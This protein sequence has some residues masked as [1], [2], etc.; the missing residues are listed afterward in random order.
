LA[1]FLNR[2]GAFSTFAAR[3]AMERGLRQ[4]LGRGQLRGIELDLGTKVRDR[5]HAGHK[6]VRA[7]RNEHDE[8]KESTLQAAANGA[9]WCTHRMDR[10]LG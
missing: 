2:I 5:V 4:L 8:A 3:A 7:K 9:H 10:Y 6:C 1:P